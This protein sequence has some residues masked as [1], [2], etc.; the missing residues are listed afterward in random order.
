MPV[1]PTYQ[2]FSSILKEPT[3]ERLGGG[4]GEGRS[5]N[6]SRS[7]GRRVEYVQTVSTSNAVTVVIFDWTV[8]LGVRVGIRVVIRVVAFT[9]LRC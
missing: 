9:S 8:R 1:C 7:H 6:A 5:I 2:F 3:S 4:R